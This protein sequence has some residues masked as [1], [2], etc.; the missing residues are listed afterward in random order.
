M[1][2]PG[3]LMTKYSTKKLSYLT[4]IIIPEDG[5]IYFLLFQAKT[6]EQIKIKLGMRVVYKL[7]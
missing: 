5:Y 1:H 2:D 6:I 7:D 4:T 3:F